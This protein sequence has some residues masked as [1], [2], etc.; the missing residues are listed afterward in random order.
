M[1]SSDTSLVSLILFFCWTPYQFY[2]L[3]PQF[4][5]WSYPISSKPPRT[6]SHRTWVYPRTG[7]KSDRIFTLPTVLYRL[8]S[9][10]ECSGMS[11]KMSLAWIGRRKRFGWTDIGYVEKG[12]YNM[13]RIWFLFFCIFFKGLIDQVYD[14]VVKLL[15]TEWLVSDVDLVVEGYC[16]FFTVI[17]FLVYWFL[18]SARRQFELIRIRQI[19]VPELILR[20]HYMLF[21]SMI[22]EYVVYSL[23]FKK[24]LLNVAS[25]FFSI[26]LFFSRNLN[27]ALQLVNIVADSR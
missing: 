22:P 11:T 5:C 1:S 15:T 23:C 2:W 16:L 12:I 6:P 21:M 7:E 3:Q 10:R 27:R 17:G 19:Y 26:F 18:F 24:K 8:G 25:F 13:T 4:S 20:L 9:S 14:R